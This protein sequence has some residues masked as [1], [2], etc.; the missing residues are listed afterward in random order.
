MIAIDNTLISEDLLDK[1]FVCDL[2]QCQ[3]ACCVKGDAGAPLE[4]DE[5]AVLNDIYRRVQPFLRPE[6]LRAI[7]EQGTSVN[8]PR[9]GEPVTPLVDGAECA[10]AIF[11]PDGTAKCGI[12]KAWEEGEVAFRKPVSCQLYPV[13]IQHYDDFDAVNYHTWKICSPACE[14]GKSLQV[15]VYRFVREALIRKYGEAWFEQLELVA[16]HWPDGE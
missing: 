6:G 12:E 4:R 5:V 11:D 9:D 13:R 14:L 1:E 2:S 16:A 15:P 7:Q 10:Y 8:D 3:G